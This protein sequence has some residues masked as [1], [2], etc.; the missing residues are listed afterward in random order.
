MSTSY[1]GIMSDRS[2]WI[3]IVDDIEGKLTVVPKNVLVQCTS[4]GE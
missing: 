2:A 3:R 4:V 1:A